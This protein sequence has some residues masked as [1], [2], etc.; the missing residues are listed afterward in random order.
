MSK[1]P[2]LLIPGMPLDGALWDHQTAFLSDIADISIP[3]HTGADS[4]GALATQILAA[5]PPRFAVA[6]LSMGGYIVMEIMRQ[7][8]E[9]VTRLA[10]LDTN[11]RADTPEQAANRRQ[12]IALAQQGKMKAVVAASIARLI[13]PDRLD[14]RP[15]VESVYAQADR[16]GVAGYANQQNAIMG[17]LDSRESL[18]AVRCPG[19]V[20]CGRQDALSGPDIHAEMADAMPGG[21]LAIIEEC[22]HLSAME[23][24]HAVTALLRDWL[25]YR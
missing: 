4:I 16:V 10:L 18:K 5:A 12:A 19:L 6:G 8:P 20:I 9:R 15:L 3:D 17:R 13:H 24:P 7:A 1:Q 2:L 22:G 11:A 23:R 14:D 25:L 21:R